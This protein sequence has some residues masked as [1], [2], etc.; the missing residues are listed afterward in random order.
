MGVP[1][2][3]RW[4]SER[5][6]KIN[7]VIT[8]EALLPE[9][10]HLYLDMNG[11]IHGCTHPSHLDVSDV[12]SERDM[13][14]GIMHYLDRIIT[15]IV[16]PKVSV[17]MAIDG[18]APRAKLN[19]QRS[20]RFRSAKDLAEA[21]KSKRIVPV[22]GA[23]VGA[24]DPY[25]GAFDSNCITPGT[26]FLL[27]ISEC[28]RYFIR[29]KIKEDPLWRNLNVIFSGPE[30]PGEGEHKIM[31]HIRDMR[32]QPGYLPNTRHCMYGQDA[33]LIML[34][35]VSHE[36]HFTLLREIIDFSGS[37]SRSDNTLKEVKKFTKQ[38]DFQLLHLSILREYLELE[39]VYKHDPSTYNLERIIDDFVFMTFLVGNDF[40]P[41]MPSLDIGDGAFTLLFDTYREQRAGWG[42]DQYLT[43]AGEISDAARLEA[44]LEV[45][46][47]AETEIFQEREKNE[48]VM[49]KKQRK[50]DQRDKTPNKTPSDM[51]LAA[52]EESKQ[53]DY[54]SMVQIMMADVSLNGTKVVDGWSP[55]VDGSQK[56]YKGRY[57]Y[58]K[59][60]FKPI[61]VSKHLALRKSYI[62]G[63]IWCL[64]YYYR[65]CISWGW[66]FPY[67]YGPM[68]SDLTNLP[69][70]FDSIKF[71]VGRPL[72]PFEQLMGCL[73]PASASLVPKP[74]RKLMCS[75][76]SPIKHFY[77]EDF[78]VDMNGK[79][80]PWEGVNILPF[81]DVKLLKESIEKNCPDTALT[82][83]ERHRNRV[84]KVYCYSYDA[85]INDTVPS[86]NRDI[87][88]PNIFKCNSRVDVIENYSEADISFRPELIPG[89]QIPY[90][91]FPSL[92]VLPIEHA[93]LRKCGLNCFGFPSKYPNMILTMRQLPQLPAAVHL[94]Q[95]FIGK[96]IF[97]NWPMMHE[98][99]V[100][101][102]SD[103]T[104]EV[105]VVKNKLTPRKFSPM[106]VERWNYLSE[107]MKEQYLV[108]AGFPGSGGV[109]IGDVQVRLKVVALQ[110][111]KTS[112]VD[113]SSMKLFGKEEAEIPLQVALLKSPAPDPR[114]DER[115]PMELKDRFPPKC[116][117]VLT[118][119]KYRGCIGTVLGSVDHEKVGVKV[120]VIP[121]EPPFGLAIARS[122]QESYISGGDAANVLRMDPRIFGK[123]VGSLFFSPGRYDLGLN[124]K[125][126]DKRYVLGYSR[127]KRD[128][129]FKKKKD[130]NAWMAGDTVLVV[131]SKR[132]SS[133]DDSGDSGED[134]KEKVIWEYTPKAVRLVAAYKNAFPQLFA[135][136]AKA[137]NERFYD[138]KKIFGPKGED[139][140][141]KVR[142]W[143]NGAE[144]A[145]I[146]R[147][148]SNT[149]AMPVAA[150]HAVQRA[151]DVRTA[152]LEKDKS[153]KESNVRVPASALYREGST[154]A[155]DVLLASEHS[156]SAPPELGDRVANLCASGVPF[157]SRGTVV[158][159]HDPAEGCVEVVMDE[160][161][162]GGSTLQGTCANFRGKLCVWNHLLKISASDSKGIIDNVMP[163]GS[164]K[165]VIEKL[166]S[167][168][169]QD[170]AD[171]KE[172][173]KKGA[174]YSEGKKVQ[175]ST[176]AKSNKA[177]G[178]DPKNPWVS[179]RPSSVPRG[180]KQKQ[181][182]WREAIGPPEKGIGFKVDR[183]ISNGF[184]AWKKLVSSERSLSTTNK[185]DSVENKVKQLT[186]NSSS[187]GLKAILG[188][189][190]EALS[191]NEHISVQTNDASTTAAAEGLKAILGVVSGGDGL[192][193]A[194]EG[195]H[196]S[197]TSAADALLQ[198][199][200]EEEQVN[201]PPPYL[202][203]QAAPKSV[204]NFTYIKEGEEQP[205]SVNLADQHHPVMYHPQMGIPNFFTPGAPMQMMPPMYGMNG[206]P[207]M[208]GHQPIPIHM[209]QPNP[210]IASGKPKTP[211]K[212]DPKSCGSGTQGK[213]SASI[214]PSV[215]VKAK[216]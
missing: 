167:D 212:R 11:I 7:Q 155:T 24:V 170:A 160:E 108:G 69:S 118:K 172:A 46:G 56:D 60:N 101:A 18:V 215:V 65:G 34:G 96:T 27:R 112:P 113:G 62:E 134:E 120:Q 180:G 74:Y 161:F 50:W 143:L 79:R 5:Y 42:H 57:Y 93:E 20:R 13:V 183:G 153:V 68:I 82:A 29:K 109:S 142:D 78:V 200:I 203:E 32:N 204:F 105:R 214:V 178:R 114:F 182:A 19:Q 17:F 103:C 39:F 3:Y 171:Q 197:E 91:G 89:T 30:V 181:G 9:F 41:H 211:V 55:N 129:S 205:L 149:E 40:L 141:A 162:I 121:P 64:A 159:I 73:P 132:M 59:L 190:N 72:K 179:P 195:G 38:S 122:V 209:N 126:K 77:P 175:P 128:P 140:C 104:H 157:G 10:D 188:V 94:A 107:M 148:P 124:L 110:G 127:V 137:P 168:I 23:D 131:G 25:S 146:P 208:T 150:V 138:A 63:L 36:P 43:N 207:H 33:D 14:L 99:K 85:A 15:Q 37:F 199:M 83:E 151:A 156:V 154:A 102:L 184:T 139:I 202:P 95:N 144:T 166:M 176:P 119:G 130:S 21:T 147:L 80:N 98:A 45:I 186:N 123:I 4:L 35:L 76:D 86:C 135:A 117:V 2:F 88:L 210:E 187:E 22:D 216:K 145:K 136:I 16:K 70:V 191:Q 163:S 213:K 97:V 198:L 8:N 133:I 92:N 173:D 44:F 12:L 196:A 116:R 84:G 201:F 28:I 48:A 58:E 1:K 193:T 67:H 169:K 31:Q 111:M 87:G 125:Y 174:K 158:A 194:A 52:R 66:F 192:S 61:D 6:P 206:H 189:K 81:I 185:S 51:E 26:E 164:G 71:E 106:E 90:P 47:A 177:P 115:G 53:S 100:V 75:P 152:A 49:L 54:I 165:A